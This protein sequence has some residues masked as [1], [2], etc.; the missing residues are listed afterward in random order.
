[1]ALRHSLCSQQGSV[2]LVAALEADGAEP[3]ERLTQRNALVVNAE[4]VEC[5]LAPKEGGSLWRTIVLQKGKQA[6]VESLVAAHEQLRDAT[7]TSEMLVAAL[8]PRTTSVAMW[9][10]GENGG[11]NEPKSV[12]RAPP[13]RQGS[14]P[15]LPY[16]HTTFLLAEHPKYDQ[17]C[18]GRGVPVNEA[19]V[20]ALLEVDK[21]PAPPEWSI[22]PAADRLAAPL[23]FRGRFVRTEREVGG[24]PVYEHV[25]KDY[26]IWFS[27]QH[28]MW[29]TTLKG[30]VDARF[31]SDRGLVALN[32]STGR[33]L[34]QLDAQWITFHD[35]ARHNLRVA[36]VPRATTA[37]QCLLVN[38]PCAPLVDLLISRASQLGPAGMLNFEMLSSPHDVSLPDPFFS[39][40]CARIRL[41]KPRSIHV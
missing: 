9:M 41:Q 15:L 11:P 16:A 40:Q 38:E 26:A 30:K 3:F 23:P 13:P 8:A 27:G 10:L 21:T 2:A 5:L 34:G 35:Q 37:L 25:E 32:R 17:R 1:M 12:S 24:R 14:T 18:P 7:L 6:I 28:G 39:A 29:F 22:E 33:N 36:R 4:V 20:Q 19:V 31:N